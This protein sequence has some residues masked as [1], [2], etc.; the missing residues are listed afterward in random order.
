M[1]VALPVAVFFTIRFDLPFYSAPIIFAGALVA[2]AY[3]AVLHFFAAEQFFRPVIEDICRV[4]PR[5]FAGMPAGVPLRWK[6]LG[7]LPVINVVTGVVVAGLTTD[8]SASLNDLG[9][10]VMVAVLVAFT[11]SLELTVLVTKSVLGP[12]DDLLEATHR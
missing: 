3:A 11:V 2:V 7:A 9:V 6:L 10:D 8:G 1:F 5:V 12:V 4:L